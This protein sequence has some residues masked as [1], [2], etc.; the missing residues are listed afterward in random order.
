MRPANEHD[1][2]EKLIETRSKQD[3]LDFFKAKS[4]DERRA[5]AELALRKFKEADRAWKQDGV[6]LTKKRFRRNSPWDEQENARVCILATATLGELKKLGW[7]ALPRDGFVLDVVRTIQPDWTSEW[8]RYLVDDEPRTFLEIRLLYDAGL[9]DKPTSDGYILGM[10]EGLPG[11][12]ARADKLWSK[13]MT[14]ANRIR[15]TPD[16]RDQDVWR[17]FEVEG[18]GELSLATFD[19]YIGDRKTGGW[20][21]ALAELAADGTLSRDRLLDESLNTLERDFAQFRAGWFSRFHEQLEPTLDERVARCEQYLRLLGSSIPPTVSFALRAIGVIDKADRL[22]PEDLLSH[23]R[24]VL[25]ARAKGTVVTALRLLARAAT[26]APAESSRAAR[27]AA[28]ALLHEAADVQMKALDLIE[29]LGGADEPEVVDAMKD[30]AD[31]IA[32]SVRERFAAM[33]GTSD[34]SADTDAPPLQASAEKT[35]DVRPIESFHEL[36]AEW[37]R[38]LEDPS[39]PLDVER[40]MDGLSRRGAARPDDFAKAMGPLAKRAA[41]IVD[42]QPD[43]RLQF[44]LAWLASAYTRGDIRQ[45][46]VKQQGD[47]ESVGSNSRR[48]TGAL[49]EVF[50]IRGAELLLQIED[51]YRLPM[52]SAPTDS[53]GFVAARSLLSRYAEYRAQGIRPGVTDMAL[54][55]QRLAPEGRSE[56]LETLEPEDETENAIAFALGGDVSIGDT[57]WL[58]V[59]AAAARRPYADRPAI[60][61]KHGHGL[62]DAGTKARY[63]VSFDKGFFTSVNVQPSMSAD[64]PK[65]YIVSRF[66]IPAAGRW[67]LWSTC[68]DHVNMIRWSATVWPLNTE[69]FFSQGLRVFNYDQR[70]AN[71][72]YAG[73]VEPMLEEHVVI[74]EVG[75]ILLIMGLASSDPAVRSVALDSAIAAIAQSRISVDLVQEALIRLLPVGRIPVGRWT[76]TLGELST[77]SKE[78]ADFV[79]ELIEGSLRHDP[80]SPPR[81]VGGLVELLY[82]LTVL[83]ETPV[84]DAKTIEYL[85]GIKS[86]GKLK[87]FAAKLLATQ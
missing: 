77:R 32:P 62:P 26:R 27:L 20:A 54:A 86:G 15:N 72:P 52:I 46:A 76:K 59:A 30:Y 19:K 64:W 45:W 6:E 61:E 53:R 74:G 83:T 70:L 18:G 58:W 67:N 84:S 63:E 37:L 13:D 24:P 75:S 8:A 51:G 28:D 16:I 34:A 31:G 50:A 81:D 49:A 79:R 1:R 22:L 80:A 65:G 47:G 48:E 39:D 40:V 41:A 38:V 14:L 9:C 42:R 21:G 68:G 69:P 2:L 87:R 71:S 55:L 5:F 85:S 43:D 10:I 36:N 3:C 4:P 11:W 35:T 57:G 7:D 56:A 82:E 78:H 33:V 29:T 66:H 25:Q 12:R 60:A 17:L 73:F 44:L 23:V